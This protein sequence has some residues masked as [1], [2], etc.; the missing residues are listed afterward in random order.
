M[1]NG[2]MNGRDRNGRWTKGHCPN[3]NGRPRKKPQTSG[4]DV[5]YF[6]QTLV[7]ATIQGKPVQLTRHELLLHKMFE[8]ALKGSVLV[9]RKL[10][11]RFEQSDDTFAE[12]E[13]HLRWLGRQICEAYDKTGQL[14][15]RLYD[16][17]RR[18]YYLIHGREHH[19]AVN[20]PKPR[21][22]KRA[23]STSSDASSWRTKPK[24]QF[25]L[26]LEKEWAEAEE[27]ERAARATSKPGS[28]DDPTDA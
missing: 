14:D 1:S 12:A 2:T 27:A 23:Q 9:Q 19:E 8:N 26:D 11:D 13:F 6:K 17:Y 18:Y 21:S 25:I 20:E 4:S 16:E 28:S 3:P 24:P 7:D 10:F 22:R 5:R 15:E